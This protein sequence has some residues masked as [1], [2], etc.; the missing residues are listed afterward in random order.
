MC[1]TV[2]GP[3]F[4][5]TIA[6]YVGWLKYAWNAWSRLTSRG[7]DAAVVIVY[8]PKSEGQ[9]AET[10]LGTFVRESAPAIDAVLRKTWSDR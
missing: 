3:N 5:S 7:D 10:V 9:D 1:R 2:A 6:R 4:F 8:T